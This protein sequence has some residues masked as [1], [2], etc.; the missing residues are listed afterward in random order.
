M[1]GR[2]KLPGH[3]RQF[4]AMRNDLSVDDGLVLYGRRIIVPKAARADVLRRLHAAHQ[5][6]VRT[7]TRARQVVY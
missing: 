6:I 5:G 2:D 1:R 4:W 7:K 3:V